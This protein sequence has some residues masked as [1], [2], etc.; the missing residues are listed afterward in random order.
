MSLKLNP[1]TGA[2]DVEIGAAVVAGGRQVARFSLF[3]MA[4]LASLPALYAYSSN[5]QG[6]TQWWG[7]WVQSWWWE[8]RM[9]A[10]CIGD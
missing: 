1:F 7:P 5:A 3:E 6:Y 2:L 9:Y 10:D 8:D 4:L